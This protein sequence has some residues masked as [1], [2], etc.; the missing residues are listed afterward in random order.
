MTDRIRSAIVPAYILLCL[1]LGG[2]VQGIYANAAL[3]LI[4]LAI[5]AWALI[6]GHQAPLSRPVRGMFLLLAGLLLLFAIQLV[7]LPTVI[8]TRLPGREAILDGYALLGVPPPWLPL[9][10]TPYETIATF[11]TLVPP[12]AV[13]LPMVL[14]RA[15]R[16]AWIAAAILVGA[17]LAVL[18]GALQVS[19][20][21]DPHSPWYLYSFSNV[22]SAVG[23]FAN[24]NHM[25]AL[26]VISVPLHVALIAHV[27]TRARRTKARSSIFVIGA[28]GLVVLAVGIVLNGSTAILLLLV[29]V[30]AVSIALLVPNR[31]S[32]K[33]LGVIAGV[34]AISILA[35][36]LSPLQQ[37]LGGANASSVAGRERMWST[38]A[39][40]A[41]DHAP[42]GS[43]IGSFRTAYPLYEKPEEVTKTVVNHAHND[44]LEI[45]METGFPGILLLVLFLAWWVQRARAMWRPQEGYL[46]G[47]AAVIVSAVLL[48]H[49]IVD[50]PLRTAALSSIMG[51]ALALMAEPRRNRSGKAEDLWSTRHIR[52]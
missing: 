23:F 34:A 35:V 37:R 18:L 36:Y 3:Q 15:N 39:R 49:S 1:V 4:G 10:V 20:A 48:I 42:F 31:S 14:I 44:Y 24:S 46:F 50:Y 41:V 22:G 52:I 45:A 27:R 33:V 5:I 16:P 30:T 21:S 38:T 28:A 19:D 43:G 32:W 2:S 12:V 7:P 47:Q 17:A 6:A 8:W 51:A 25:A 9:S 26:L 11:L 13:V 40:A 29:P